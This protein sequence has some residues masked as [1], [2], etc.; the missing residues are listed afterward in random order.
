[1]CITEY[2]AQ[3]CYTLGMCKIYIYC[4][5]KPAGKIICSLFKM[6]AIQLLLIPSVFTKQES[7]VNYM[8]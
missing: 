1:M 3:V 6:H 8:F 5:M 4:P 7:L 2:T